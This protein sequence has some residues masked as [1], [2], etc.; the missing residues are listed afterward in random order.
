MVEYDTFNV[1][2]AGSI[3]AG[4]TLKINNGREVLMETFLTVTQRIAGSIPVTPARFVVKKEF[5]RR[6][7]Q[8]R[9]LYQASIRLVKNALFDFL[10]SY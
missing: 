10:K 3:P 2:V 5:H 6:L 8:V 7:P 9:L 1:G 4:P